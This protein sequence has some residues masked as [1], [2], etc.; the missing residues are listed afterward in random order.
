[1]LILDI[2][3]PAGVVGMGQTY[4]GVEDAIRAFLDTIP[5]D[6][7]AGPVPLLVN[8][9]LRVS[10]AGRTWA[11][12]TFEPSPTG[13]T[14]PVCVVLWHGHWRTYVATVFGWESH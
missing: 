1:M 10:H 9:V 14:W 5:M 2:I 13:G 12:G 11:V 8:T 4:A 6:R 7:G 3:T